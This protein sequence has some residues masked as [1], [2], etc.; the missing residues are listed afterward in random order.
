MAGWSEPAFDDSRWRKVA[1]DESLGKAELVSQRNE[2][3]RI[4]R[5]LEPVE[6]P[7]TGFRPVKSYYYW[8]LGA[9][10][11]L[12]GLLC[13]ATLL[14]RVVLRRRAGRPAHAG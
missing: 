11:A 10:F 4:L 8:P 7:E 1:V 14:E 3:I 2:P 12:V 13:V 6:E 9:A 5:E